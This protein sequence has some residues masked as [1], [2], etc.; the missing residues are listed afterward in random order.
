MDILLVGPGLEDDT[1]SQA[2]RQISYLE[3]QAF[4]APHAILTVAGLTPA[5]HRVTIHDEPLHG[6]VEPLLAQRH[7]D[8]IGV[9]LSTGQ[10]RRTI[11]IGEHCRRQGLTSTLVTGGFGMGYVSEHLTQLFDVLFLGEVEDLWA[12]FLDDLERGEVR[13][14]YQ[15]ETRPDMAKAVTPRWD[16]VAPDVPAYTATSVQTT[17]GCPFD[18]HFC[19]VITTYGRKP[20]TKTI[21]QVLH[22]VRLLEG[23]GARMVYLADDNLAGNRPYARKL[24]REL[25]Q[26][27]NGFEMP[28][29]FITQL[30]L[31]VSKDEEL[32]ALLADANLVEVQIGIESSAEAS[33][34]EMNKLQ[35]LALDPVAAVRKIQS[36]GIMVLGHMIVGADADDAGVF[37]RMRRFVID[38]QLARHICHPLMAVPGSKMHE[39]WRRQGRVLRQSVEGF[40][41]LDIVSNVVPKLMTRVELMEGLADYHEA[42][43]APAAYVERAVGFLRGI[44]R[45]PRVKSGG[46]GDAWRMRKMLARTLKFYSFSVPAEDRRVFFRVLGETRKRST[47]LMP[48]AVYMHTGYM[49]ERARGKAVA[50]ILRDQAQRER[51]DP[52]LVV[53][54]AV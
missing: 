49:I 46:L 8:V 3:T 7:F 19:E 2:A 44:E 30:D 41:R 24:L 32:L 26:L 43:Y 10:L 42:I 51:E 40:D 13:P 9:T 47:Q 1:I 23:L 29:S 20:R 16:L 22:E 25:A 5:R 17:R 48:N 18:C 12:G 50:A 14:V 21:E 45:L 6:P 31:T 4:F 27:N 36:Y 37:E 38:A 34:R 15:A 35:N 33:L 54:L 11:A 52:T 53:P 39:E 28:L